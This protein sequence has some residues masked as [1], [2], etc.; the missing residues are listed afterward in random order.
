MPGLQGMLAYQPRL[1]VQRQ[2]RKIAPPLVGSGQLSQCVRAGSNGK[3]CPHTLLVSR[4][5]G[6]WKLQPLLALQ[7]Y[8]LLPLA[9]FSRW[10]LI[11]DPR[12]ADRRSRQHL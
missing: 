11:F 3:R 9:S 1:G 10:L 8:H 7:V 5:P 4:H 2:L 6:S 12:T